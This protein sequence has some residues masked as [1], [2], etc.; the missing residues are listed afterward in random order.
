MYTGHYVH[1]QTSRYMGGYDGP[2]QS[3]EKILSVQIL[4]YRHSLN[5]YTHYV[6]PSSIVHVVLCVHCELSVVYTK[7]VTLKVRSN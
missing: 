5:L 6:T 1:R 2:V 3:E 4:S 7:E